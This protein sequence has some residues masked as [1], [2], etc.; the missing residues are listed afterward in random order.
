MSARQAPTPRPEEVELWHVLPAAVV[1]G[2]ER[3]L[4]SLI[5]HLR[6]AGWSQRLVLLR[7]GPLDPAFRELLGPEAITSLHLDLARPVKSLATARSFRRNLGRNRPRRRLLQGWLYL[8]NG[9]ASWLSPA[10]AGA[11]VVWSV[12]ATMD[13]PG[14]L[15]WPSRLAFLLSKPRARTES[16][17]AAIV[18][19]TDAS[20]RCHEG[21]GYPAPLGLTIEN[22]LDLVAFAGLEPQR[23]ATRAELGLDPETTL[24][25]TLARLDPMKDHGNLLAAYGC[26]REPGRTAL[27]L[28]GQGAESGNPD[29]AG[30]LSTAG[31]PAEAPDILALGARDDIRPY[32]AAADVSVLSSAYGEALPLSVLESLAAGRPIVA[33][34]IGGLPDLSRA[35]GSPPALRLVPPRDPEALANAMEQQAKLGMS[36]PER[37]ALQARLRETYAL[38]ACAQRYHALYQ[39]VLAEPH[40]DDLGRRR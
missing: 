16:G 31:L 12:H 22:G 20:R 15:H 9:F 30:L 37:S 36:D 5:P 23:A 21:L 6:Q 4:L 19:C 17:P 27:L 3:L 18:Y 7:D 32:L 28:L 38:E 35:L 11:P 14:Q 2:A 26:L 1:G 34:A 10:L 25:V 39:E 29:L 33:T 40:A 24:F 13:R 8:G